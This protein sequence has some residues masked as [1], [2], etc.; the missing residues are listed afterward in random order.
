MLTHIVKDTIPETS[1]RPRGH[2]VCWDAWAA[3]QPRWAA[4]G[5]QDPLQLHRLRHRHRHRRPHRPP[6]LQ[7]MCSLMSDMQVITWSYKAL[8]AWMITQASLSS[9]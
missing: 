6:P 7:H 8:L 5:W 9:S 1:L 4:A 2:L 3:W